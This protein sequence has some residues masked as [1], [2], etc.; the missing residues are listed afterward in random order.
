MSEDRYC[1]QCNRWKDIEHFRGI[2][3]TFVK[4]CDEC[5]ARRPGGIYQRVEPRQ[6]LRTDAP[7]PRVI[8]APKSNN[9]KLGGIGAAIIT[10]E[11]CPPSCSF[12]GNGCY[13]ELGQSK[14]HWARA[15]DK[16]LTWEAFL[17]EIR[18]LPHGALWRYGVSGDLPGVGEALDHER[19]RSL[20]SANSGARGFGFTHKPLDGHGD[21]AHVRQA[22]LRGFTI[23]LSADGLEHADA[24]AALG[25]A[26]V[27]IVVPRDAPVKMRTP[28]GRPVFVCPAQTS[29]HTCASCQLCS[30]A[31]RVGIVAFRAH[32]TMSKT[33][34][35]VVSRPRRQ[36]PVVREEQGE[37]A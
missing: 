37:S 3:V 36:L 23:N 7:E 34:S 25:V 20:V 13:A 11:T 8:W 30:R 33:V 1:G 6:R 17:N 18:A 19:F 10:A 5:R 27:A 2:R 15:Q 32:G 22:N 35:E 16:G 28:G 12:Y 9:A 29:D 24:R 14:H 21:A 31:E 4:M 26:P